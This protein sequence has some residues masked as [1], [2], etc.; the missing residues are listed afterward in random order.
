MLTIMSDTIYNVHAVYEQQGFW[1]HQILV[2]VAERVERVIRA[3]TVCL[4]ERF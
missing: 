1:C 3:T 4:L 2:Q